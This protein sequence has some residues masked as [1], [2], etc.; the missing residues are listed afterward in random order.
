MNIWDDESQSSAQ[1]SGHFSLDFQSS[2]SHFV[3]CDQD[4]EYAIEIT[5]SLKLK[6]LLGIYVPHPFM[7]KLFCFPFY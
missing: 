2:Q 3:G 6:E 4:S 1:I 7:L 5:L